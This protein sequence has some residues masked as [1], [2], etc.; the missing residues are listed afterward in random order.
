MEMIRTGLRIFD[1]I[2]YH[3]SL[4][5]ELRSSNLKKF[6]NYKNQILGFG[7]SSVGHNS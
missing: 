7:C 1:T 6:K 2:C 3:L 4:A 5:H